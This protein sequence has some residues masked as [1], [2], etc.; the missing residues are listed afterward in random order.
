[1]IP[2]LLEFLAL[3][4]N[5]LSGI[6]AAVL[7]VAGGFMLRYLMVEIG[8]VS[9]WHDYAIQFDPQLLQRLMP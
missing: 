9:T 6:T 4:G 5:R 8:Q 2:L 7:V 1:L 3:R